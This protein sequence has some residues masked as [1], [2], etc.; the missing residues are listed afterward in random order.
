MANNPLV[1]LYFLVFYYENVLVQIVKSR[2]CTCYVYC[3]LLTG[4]RLYVRYMVEL[5]YV[6]MPDY[7]ERAKL[8]KY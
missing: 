1:S 5:C 7:V 8:M 2:L 4:H 3:I 6:R